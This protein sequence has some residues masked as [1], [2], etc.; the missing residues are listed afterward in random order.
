MTQTTT[1]YSQLPTIESERLILRKLE[2][3]DADD[4]FQYASEF[5]VSRFMP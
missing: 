4:M 1:V 5:S 3:T 2:A